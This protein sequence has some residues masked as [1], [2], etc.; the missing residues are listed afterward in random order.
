MINW[1][2]ELIMIGKHNPKYF[3]RKLQQARKQVENKI[4]DSQWLEY[5]KTLYDRP[6]D[7]VSLPTTNNLKELFSNEE[8]TLGIRILASGKA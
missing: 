4:V 7:E 3:W 2:K 5:A 8:I 6:K 1:R